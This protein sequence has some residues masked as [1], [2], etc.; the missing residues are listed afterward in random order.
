[1]KKDTGFEMRRVFTLLGFLLFV[2][3][4]TLS[5][6]TGDDAAAAS[7]KPAVTTRQPAA[8]YSDREAHPPAPANDSQSFVEWLQE[9]ETVTLSMITDLKKLKEERFKQDYQPARIT[10]RNGTL[11]FREEGKV[12]TRGNYRCRHCR[13]PPVKIKIPKK[14]MQEAGFTEWNEFKLVLP[15]GRGKAFEQ[16][17]LKEYLIYRLYNILTEKSFRVRHLNLHLKDT[18]EED[19]YFTP[20]A[21]LIEHTEEAESRLGGVEIERQDFNPDSFSREDYTRMQIFHYMIGNTDWLP[22]TGQNLKV[23]QLTDGRM[24]PIPYDFDFSG[25]VRAEYAVPNPLTG[26]NRIGPRFFMG[27][28]KT[29]AELEAIFEEFREKKRT[30]FNTI[31][32]FEPLDYR[33]RKRMIRYLQGFFKTIDNPQ[34]VRHEFLD[35]PPFMMPMY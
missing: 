12:R 31:A 27:N 14:K 16:Y 23:I 6:Q 11:E 10:V 8:V 26:L 3:S 29:E 17:V 33:E 20:A 21:F 32:H 4:F 24:I 18:E 25:L 19:S 35:K 13:L 15:C 28:N 22:V 34:R 1:M 9:G 7:T 30:L 5:A 2:F